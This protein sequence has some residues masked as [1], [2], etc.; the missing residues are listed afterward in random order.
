MHCEI[1][2]DKADG[3]RWRITANNGKVVG[4]S[5]ESYFS[6][7]NAKRNLVRTIKEAIVVTKWKS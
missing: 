7:W 1:Y 2:K 5:T 3:W 6:R 4:A